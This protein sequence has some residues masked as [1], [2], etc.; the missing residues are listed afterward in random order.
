ME[1]VSSYFIRHWTKSLSWAI[2]DV[3]I[4]YFIIQNILKIC[5]TCFHTRKEC[6]SVTNTGLYSPSCC[7]SPL[8]W[9]HLVLS[10]SYMSNDFFW[11]MCFTSQNLLR[12][13]LVAFGAQLPQERF[14]YMNYRLNSSRPVW[15]GRQWEGTSIL[16][17]YLE[18]SRSPMLL[19][20]DHLLPVRN[21]TTPSECCF[22]AEWISFPHKG[23]LKGLS[24]TSCFR[25]LVLKDGVQQVDQQD[26]L[27]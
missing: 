27:T 4:L 11:W 16:F 22:P 6:L 1:T 23:I 14:K 20:A 8:Y 12:L 19:N 24:C 25:A 15:R 26:P 7:F 17:Q 13:M 10:L 9:Q 3:V 21:L 5:S 18:T 2:A